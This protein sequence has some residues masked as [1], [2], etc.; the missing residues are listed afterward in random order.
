MSEPD[1]SEQL[2]RAVEV[3][4]GELESLTRRAE[5]AEAKLALYEAV[6]E[7]ANDFCNSGVCIES[8]NQDR[9]QDVLIAALARLREGG[10]K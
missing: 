6:A 9:K 3:V 4:L 8:P 2:E 7:A 5:E 1:I 10:N